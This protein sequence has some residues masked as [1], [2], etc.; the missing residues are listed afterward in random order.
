MLYIFGFSLLQA[1][2]VKRGDLISTCVIL[3]LRLCTRVCARM[4]ACD[5]FAAKSSYFV[6]YKVGSEL[7]L[8]CSARS[9]RSQDAKLTQISVPQ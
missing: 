2:L 4:K 1:F 8:K 6:G 3:D 5:D 9:V 7:Y